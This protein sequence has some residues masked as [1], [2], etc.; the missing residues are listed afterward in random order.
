MSYTR[1]SKKNMQTYINPF[2]PSF[3]PSFLFDASCLGVYPPLF[4]SKKGIVVNYYIILYLRPFVF[5]SK[6][7][8][9]ETLISFDRMIF[10]LKNPAF[11]II[12][13]RYPNDQL[14]VMQLKP[15]NG[16]QFILFSKNK[17][18]TN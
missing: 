17:N 5:Q 13:R 16:W 7:F 2:L 9:N 15:L 3:L 1:Y 10:F 8:N 18:F 4:T 6:D 11:F 14:L 12:I